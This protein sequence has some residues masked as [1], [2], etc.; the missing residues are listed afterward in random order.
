[1]PLGSVSKEIHHR[2]IVSRR[3]AATESDIKELIKAA[4]HGDQG[5]G[6]VVTAKQRNL[7][8]FPDPTTG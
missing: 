2:R 6:T 5:D 3:Y 8:Y 4:M 1:M 7:L